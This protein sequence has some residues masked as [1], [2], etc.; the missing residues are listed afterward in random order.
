MV[1]LA[2]ILFILVT[3]IFVWGRPHLRR[4]KAQDDMFAARYVQRQQEVLALSVEDAYRQAELLLVNPQKFYCIPL[5][6]PAENFDV[7][8]PNLQALFSRFKTIEAVDT[9]YFLERELIS[10]FGWDCEE[11]PWRKHQFWQIGAGHEHSIILVKPHQEGVYD[12]DGTDDDLEE[13]SYPTI[14]HWL[15]MAASDFSL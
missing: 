9:E 12:T 13:P 10:P 11:S 15:L 7:L 2:V 4:M 1:L 6:Q 3:L 14:Y 8:A 5:A